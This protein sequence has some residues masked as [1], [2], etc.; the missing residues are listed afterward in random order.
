VP[1]IA[2][3]CV[4]FADVCRHRPVPA[5][6]RT[7]PADEQ[8]GAPR[9][10]VQPMGALG[11]QARHL[12]SS[13]EVVASALVTT[14]NLRLGCGS[15]G[16]C[17]AALRP[18]ARCQTPLNPSCPGTCPSPDARNCADFAG[19]ENRQQLIPKRRRPSHQQ[20]PLFLRRAKMTVRAGHGFGGRLR[21]TVTKWLWQRELTVRHNTPSIWRIPSLVVADGLSVPGPR[22]RR[23]LH[24]FRTL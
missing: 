7:P 10:P 5:A 2:G 3:L 16:T 23:E 4:Q 1:L 20:T 9:V 19:A 24:T 11:A 13:G 21:W 8:V 14:P 12:R 18:G 15:T 17:K 6:P 22:N